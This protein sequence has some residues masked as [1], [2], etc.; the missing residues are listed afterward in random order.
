[1]NFRSTNQTNIQI[2]HKDNNINNVI[3]TRLGRGN[4]TDNTLRQN[5]TDPDDINP[6]EQPHVRTRSLSS[7]GEN[8]SYR[9]PVI[10]RKVQDIPPAVPQT[11][12]PIT[13]Q[14]KRQGT[15][16]AVA[17]ECSTTPPLH[18]LGQAKGKEQTRQSR[19]ADPQYQNK[20]KH[21]VFRLAPKI[22]SS[23]HDN[24]GRHRRPHHLAMNL[25]TAPKTSSSGHYPLEGTEDLIIWS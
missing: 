21:L 25:C 3:Y 22:S 23:G 8:T 18:R 1:M 10:Y 16:S 7:T 14:A 19:P 17:N 9:E 6:V 24:F 4:K 11:H 15:V 12:F 2:T 13:G 5:K 20:A